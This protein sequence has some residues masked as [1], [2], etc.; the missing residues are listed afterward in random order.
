MLIS[1]NNLITGK[2]LLNKKIWMFLNRFQVHLKLWS[3][4]GKNKMIKDVHR[5]IPI[6]AGGMVII[7]LAK[8]KISSSFFIGVCTVYIVIVSIMIYKSGENLRKKRN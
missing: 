1:K 7:I 5:Y 3:W 6:L 8:D 2:Q 4:N